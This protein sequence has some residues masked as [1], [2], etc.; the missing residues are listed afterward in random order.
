[1]ITF[2]CYLFLF[3]YT[4]LYCACAVIPLCIGLFLCGFQR[5]RIGFLLRFLIL[6]YGRGVI[7]LVLRPFASVRFE[8]LEPSC[9]FGIFIFN[10]RS[11]SDPFLV[12]VL[13]TLKPCV[14]AVNRWP[15][16]LPFFGFFASLG[17]YIDVTAM[18][19]EQILQKASSLLGSGVPLAVFPEGTRSG[20]RVM[21][22]FHGTF[23]R[24]AK[25]LA[26]PLIPV[27]VTGNERIPD[28]DFRMSRGRIHI[29]KLPA[30]TPD[31]IADLP[32]F[33]LKNRVRAILLAETEK[34]DAGL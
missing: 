34:M 33:Q 1:M 17:E 26:C 14:Q 30:L 24:I 25:E 27:A 20:G 12:S 5:K 18:S 2:T 11:A 22:P 9:R 29:R 4:I 3:L 23:F 32:P 10:H 7:S 21:N 13:R 15:M 6:W 8:D 28:R 16:R 19:Y 31:R